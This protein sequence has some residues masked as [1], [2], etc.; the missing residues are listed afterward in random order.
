MGSEEVRLKP[1]ATYD[2]EASAGT[3]SY[4]ASAF[5]R[6]SVVAPGFSPTFVNVARRAS[7]AS[8]RVVRRCAIACASVPLRRTTPIPPRPGGV[9]MATMVSAVENTVVQSRQSKVEGPQ[10]ERSTVDAF[11]LSTVDSRLSTL[12]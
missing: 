5:R 6:T 3:V 12:D 10:S 8:R 1:D 11:R 7:N 2:L 4:V 9:A